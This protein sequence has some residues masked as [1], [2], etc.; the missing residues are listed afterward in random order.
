[1]LGRWALGCFNALPAEKP[2]LYCGT[3]LFDETPAWYWIDSDPQR[4]IIDYHVGDAER[5]FPR[6][7]TRIVPGP[8][9]GRDAV[10]CIVT[11]TAWRPVDMSDDRWHRL[12]AAHEA[13][14]LIIQAQLI[15]EANR[16]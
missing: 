11:M 6:I 9:Y 13:E 1:M 15:S 2:G 14:I 5:Q 4:W 3:S 12:C 7:S 8:H 10:H 16:I